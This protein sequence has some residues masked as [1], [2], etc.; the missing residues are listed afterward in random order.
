M[1]SELPAGGVA[2]VTGAANGIGQAMAENFAR[3]RMAVVAVDL[4]R[5]ALDARVPELEQLGAAAVAVHAVDVTDPTQVDAVAEATW[6]RFGRVD[7][8]CN[9]AG[10]G[11]D[12]SLELWSGPLESWHAVFAVNFFGVLHGVR[13]FAPRMVAQDRA[14]HIVN[15]ASMAGVVGN[16]WISEY[17]VSK[18]A[19]VGLTKSLR[20]QLAS[21]H[22]LVGASVLC[23]GPVDT[24]RMKQ[25][26]ANA[27]PGVDQFS[28]GTSVEPAEVASCVAQA[29]LADRFWIFTNPGSAARIDEDLASL[30]EAAAIP[31]T[32]G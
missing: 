29:I 14:S 21:Q 11:S 9:N 27:R 6:Q 16:G 8:L 12:A 20:I 2:V 32:R 30:L 31:E 15:T 19:V 26:R 1:S 7:V 25:A 24:E 28:K 17:S 10:I 23:P 4:D 13:A 22:P 18:Y 3:R 5:D